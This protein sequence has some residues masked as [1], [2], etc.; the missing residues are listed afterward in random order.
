[1]KKM[2]KKVEITDEMIKEYNKQVMLRAKAW[3][4]IFERTN[5]PF[6]KEHFMKITKITEE[7]FNEITK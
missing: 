1:M 7:Q 4:K 6:T 5:T 2:N 3:L